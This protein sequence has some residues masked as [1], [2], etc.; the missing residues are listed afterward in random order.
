MQWHCRLGHPSLPVLKR[1]VAELSHLSSLSCEVCQLSKHCWSSFKSSLVE[2]VSSPFELVHSYVCGAIPNNHFRYFVTLIVFLL[3]DSTERL[4]SK[5][6]QGQ[7]PP[8][9]YLGLPVVFISN[10]LAISNISLITK[11]WCR[12]KSSQNAFLDFYYCLHLWKT[13]LIPS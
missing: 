2:R 12:Y 5:F 13:A 11:W 1:Q 8:F 10:W 3:R 9:K 6:S 7:R 4:E